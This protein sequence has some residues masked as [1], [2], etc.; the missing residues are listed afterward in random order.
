MDSPPC[1]AIFFSKQK[2]FN[3]KWIP[4]TYFAFFFFAAGKIRN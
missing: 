3:R 1:F 4:P 2:N